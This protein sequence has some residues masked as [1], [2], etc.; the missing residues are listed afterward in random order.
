M[1]SLCSAREV[2]IFWPL[3][4]HVSP[5]RSAR[6]LMAVVSDPAV[7]S[8][9]PNAWRRTSPLGD[10]GQVALL[11]LLGTVAEHGAHHVHLG[12]AGARIATARRDLLEDHRRAGEARARRRRTARGSAPTTIRASSGRRRTR[13]GSDPVRGRASTRCR[14]CRRGGAPRCGWWRNR[15]RRPSCVVLPET[16]SAQRLGCCGAALT[17]MVLHGAPCP[18]GVAIGDR[19]QDRRVIGHRVGVHTRGE[20]VVVGRDRTLEQRQQPNAFGAARRD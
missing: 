9:T 20:L 14:T 8:V 16:L 2:Q 10:A 1:R 17:E 3:I 5:S 7:G 4:R 19:S 15:A 18:V 11:L 13:S 12:V 6:V